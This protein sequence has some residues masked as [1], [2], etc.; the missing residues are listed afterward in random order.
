MSEILKTIESMR[1]TSSGRGVTYWSTAAKCGRKANLIEQ[2][3]LRYQDSMTE[4]GEDGKVNRLTIGAHFATLME[5][6]QKRT[7]PDGTLRDYDE[8]T[9]SPELEE[10]LRLFEFY[11]AQR[12]RD[13]WG[14]VVAV[15]L[16]IPTTPQGAQLMKE[17]FGDETT[18]R[19]D[20]LV[21]MSEAD[22]ARHESNHGLTLDGPGLYIIDQKTGGKHGAM[23]YW[24]YTF[25]DQGLLYQ[26]IWNTENPDKQVKG[27]VFDRIVSHTKLTEKSFAAYV[28]KAQP[29]DE[30]IFRNLVQIG[31]RNVETNEANSAMCFDGFKPCYFFVSGQCPRK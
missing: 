8:M 10:A 19:T 2:N 30:E 29:G 26:Y 24:K 20:L 25:G 4:P 17:Y 5:M 9:H 31:K 21:E 13:Y 18:G 6:W 1:T 12:A 15:E 11:R 14:R 22:V 3:A 28:C 23:D 27:M 7:L 16:K